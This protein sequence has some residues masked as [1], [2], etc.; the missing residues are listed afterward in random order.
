MVANLFINEKY[1]DPDFQA[2]L[3]DELAR[4]GSQG[5]RLQRFFRE[6][7]EHDPGGW[8]DAYI[9]PGRLE[10]LGD[11][12]KILDSPFSDDELRKGIASGLETQRALAVYFFHAAAEGI[13]GKPGPEQRIDPL[14]ISLDPA[15]WESEGLVSE[16]GLT[17]E[18]ARALAPG[19]DRLLVG[20]PA[21]VTAVGG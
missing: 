20:T 7:A 14:K 19:I 12:Q 6:W 3:T 1:D 8:E 9:S 4:L 18:E 5:T 10:F 2:S 17:L 16:S 13:P 11:R 15:R 21:P